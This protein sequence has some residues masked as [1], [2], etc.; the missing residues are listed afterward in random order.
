MKKRNIQLLTQTRKIDDHQTKGDER[1][2]AV[3]ASARNT[4]IATGIGRVLVEAQIGT[5]GS[6]RLTVDLSQIGIIQTTQL[7]L[8]TRSQQSTHQQ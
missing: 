6:P 8:R 4:H 3:I 7:S 1:D 5:Q 2:L